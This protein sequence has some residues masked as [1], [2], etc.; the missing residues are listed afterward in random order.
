MAVFIT[1]I[2]YIKKL[3]A[4]FTQRTPTTPSFTTSSPKDSSQINYYDTSR[5]K[6]THQIYD[7][8]NDDLDEQKGG[9]A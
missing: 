3:I 4:N 9:D 5:F 6:V 8:V 2:D 1:G 7:P